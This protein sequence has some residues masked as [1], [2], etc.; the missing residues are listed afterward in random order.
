M[1][2]IEHATNGEEPYAEAKVMH[3]KEKKNNVHTGG[4]YCGSLY[5]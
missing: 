2:K 4:L 3:H 1:W 5:N